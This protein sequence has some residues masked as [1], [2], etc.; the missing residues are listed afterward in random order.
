[1]KR[2]APARRRQHGATLIEVLVSLIILMVGLLGWS[3]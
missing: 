3:A 1:M 2:R